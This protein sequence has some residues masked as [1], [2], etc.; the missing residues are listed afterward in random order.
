MLIDKPFSCL[1]RPG[2]QAEFG[3]LV[4]ISQQA[5]SG[6]AARGVLAPGATLRQWLLDYCAAIREA[7]SGRGGEATTQQQ[8]AEARI[9]ESIAKATRYEVETAEKLSKLVD[10]DFIE[11]QLAGWAAAGVQAVESA[12]ERIADGI[13]AEFGIELEDRHVIGHLRDALRDISTYPLARAR[14]DAE[15]GER[16]DSERSDPDS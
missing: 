12:A 6:I 5:V 4:G 7:A 16:M 10:A 2:S 15:S 11:Q 3:V 13:S 8:L 9:R 1:D 14:D